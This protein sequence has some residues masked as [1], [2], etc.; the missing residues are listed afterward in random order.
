MS[1]RGAKTQARLRK[2]ALQAFEELGWQATRVQDVVER[3]GVS[4]GTFY[5]YYDNKAAVLIDLV[6]DSQAAL[7][8]LA[9]QPW[10]AEDARGAL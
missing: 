6:A 8:A 5:T 7:L 3:A 4:H 1:G 2:A 9:L 10:E